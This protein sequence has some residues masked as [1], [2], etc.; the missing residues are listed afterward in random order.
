VNFINRSL[1]RTA[2]SA[3]LFEAARQVIPGGVN[4]TARAQ[5]SG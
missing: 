4:S 1:S 5:W 2:N 3:A